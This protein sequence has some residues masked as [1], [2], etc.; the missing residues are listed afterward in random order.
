MKLIAFRILV[1]SLLIGMG[2][3]LGSCKKKE[4]QAANN[5][6]T[7]VL[8]FHITGGG[9]PFALNKTIINAFGQQYSFDVFAFYASDV[10]LTGTK[11]YYADSILLID[12][13]DSEIKINPSLVDTMF[14]LSVPAG[15]YTGLQFGIGPDKQQNGQGGSIYATRYQPPKSP[16]SG[17]FAEYYWGVSLGYLFFTAQGTYDSVANITGGLN[18][19]FFYHCGTD[20]FLV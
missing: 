2:F 6:G 9:Q 7:S 16:L 1:F 14:T 12:A 3:G 18:S 15:T 17:T 8:K 13:N 11:S 10:T 4:Q 20:R 19:D 5:N